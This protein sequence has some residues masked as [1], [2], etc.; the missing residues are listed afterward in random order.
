[1]PPERGTDFGKRHVQKQEPERSRRALGSGLIAH[2]QKMMVA[3]RA[4]AEKKA[5]GHLS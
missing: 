4:M 5:F 3:A 1:M 2:S